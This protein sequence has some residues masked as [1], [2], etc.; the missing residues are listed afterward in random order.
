MSDRE[1]ILRMLDGERT[2]EIFCSC[3]VL[4]TIWDVMDELNVYWPDA[5]MDPDLMAKLG[6]SSYTLLGYQSV[7][8]GFDAGLEAQAL[9]AEV[10]MGSRKSPVCITKPAF[11]D[12]DAFA[13]PKNLF[14]L[15]RFPVHL[16]AVSILAEKYSDKVPVYAR[17]PGPM[18]FLGHLFGIEKTMRWTMKEPSLFQRLLEKVSD[19]I[20]PMGNLLIERGADVLSMADPNASGDMVS[21]RIFN[22]FMMPIYKKL[23]EE[24]KGRIV[25]HI[26]GDITPVLSSIVETGF[27]ALSFEGPTV[28]V[29]KVKEIIGDRM[30]LFGNIPTVEV[31]MRG[32]VEDV[33]RAVR[34][35][36]ECGIDSV[37]PACSMPL[38]TPINNARAISESVRDYNK[39]KCNTLAL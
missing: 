18:T 15:G 16:K 23:S 11:D 22:K 25:L 7:R 28:K 4:A 39:N 12:P 26:C 6:E 38:Q 5:H 10:K 31:L 30:A 3:N 1:K 32:T 34:E 36:I 9:G 8:S 27:C 24:I 13:V 33:R 19:I 29:G 21:P 2:G 14:E 17:L 20:V 37:A 35:A